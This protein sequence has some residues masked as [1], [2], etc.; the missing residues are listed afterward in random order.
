MSGIVHGSLEPGAAAELGILF[1][2]VVVSFHLLARSLLC[3]LL[4]VDFVSIRSRNSASSHAPLART[5][6]R[7][8]PVTTGPYHNRRETGVHTLPNRRTRP[9]TGVVCGS[10]SGSNATYIY[11]GL[12]TPQKKA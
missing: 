11:N 5:S 3:R 12:R 1:R 7:Y 6:Q 9:R 10:K 2:F 4:A 8:T